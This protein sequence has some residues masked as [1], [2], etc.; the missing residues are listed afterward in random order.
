MAHRI[1]RAGLS[2]RSCSVARRRRAGARVERPA[3]RVRHR[4]RQGRVRRV[5][6]HRPERRGE[7][8]SSSPTG[9]ATSTRS[10]A[11]TPPPWRS[12]SR[13]PASPS[14]TRT[15]TSTTTRRSSPRSRRSSR[16]ASRPVATSSCVTDWM[17]ARMIDLGWIQKLDHANMPNVDANLIDFLKSPD[18]DPNRDYSVPWQSGMTGIC[19]NSELTDPVT[20]LRGAAHPTR[21]QGQGRA[22]HR[23]AR[24]D[25][26]SCC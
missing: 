1:E 26:A 17:A 2:R 22:A 19:Y 8:R 3:R 21:P 10:S 15:A 4:G 14:T 13:R 16:P 25:A 12:S 5:R 18:W 24:H 11:R 7:A 6:E 23:D 9:S 20:Q